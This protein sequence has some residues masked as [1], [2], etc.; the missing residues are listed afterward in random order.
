MNG[1]RQDDKLLS[2]IDLLR[3]KTEQGD[4]AWAQTRPRCWYCKTM[5]HGITLQSFDHRVEITLVHF[6]SDREHQLEELTDVE[7]GPL[8]RL[9]QAIAGPEEAA[10]AAN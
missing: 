8:A 9:A 1:M 7:H 10:V 5:D 3:A 4:I 6:I 2:V